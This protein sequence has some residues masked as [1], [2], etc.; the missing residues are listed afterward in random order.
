M[1]N[2]TEIDLGENHIG[3]YFLIALTG[4]STIYFLYAVATH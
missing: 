1:E 2:K 3:D 4:S